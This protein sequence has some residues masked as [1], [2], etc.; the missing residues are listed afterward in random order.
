MLR[1]YKFIVQAVPQV[2]DDEGNVVGESTDVQPV[3]LF[4]C[5]ALAKWADE[6]PVKLAEAEKALT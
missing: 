4:G 5:D 2:L 3:A 1:P 6:F